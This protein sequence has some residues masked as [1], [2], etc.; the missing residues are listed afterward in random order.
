V[1]LS[2][3]EDF[4][5]RPVLGNIVEGFR[6]QLTVYENIAMTRLLPATFLLGQLAAATLGQRDG[7]KYPDYSL[8]ESCPGYRASNFK[9]T[10][11]GLTA[12][13]ALAG[14]AC[15]VYGKDFDSLTLEVTYETG[16]L[17]SLI[18]QGFGALAND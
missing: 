5:L 15:D 12:D 6:R 13:M 4:I 10:P 11:S 1:L 3:W 18:S 17:V 8:I 9:Q 16:D 14:K 2:V 7:K